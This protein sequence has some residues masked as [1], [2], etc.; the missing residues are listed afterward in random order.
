M[1]FINKNSAIRCW[2]LKDF[3]NFVLQDLTCTSM[4]R[5]SFKAPTLTWDHSIDTQT[6]EQRKGA[7]HSGKCRGKLWKFTTIIHVR[8]IRF[9]LYVPPLCVC[10]TPLIGYEEY[11]VVRS[12][13]TKPLTKCG[14]LLVSSKCS[15]RVVWKTVDLVCLL[16]RSIS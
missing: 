15:S 8:V 2:F 10:R 1:L 13:T 3:F 6:C 12:R 9:C 11:D 4:L 16:V 5:I 7:L 14:L